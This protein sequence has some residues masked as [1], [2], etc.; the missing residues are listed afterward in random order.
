M[1]RSLTVAYS[2]ASGFQL[3]S[4]PAFTPY[5]RYKFT[6]DSGTNQSGPF[7]FETKL[8]DTPL[9]GQVL[10]L[11]AF[12]SNAMV[13]PV[14]RIGNN[15]ELDLSAGLLGQRSIVNKFGASNSVSNSEIVLTIDGANFAG[16]LTAASAVRIKAGGD[17]ADDASGLGAREITIEGLDGS[18]NAVSESV[19]TAGASASSATTATFLRITR[20]YVSAEGV[21]SD[22]VTG[23]NEAAVTVE[24]TGG[25]QM[26]QIA[27]GAGQSEHAAY[28]VPAGFTA[29]LVAFG[30]F[31][32]SAQSAAVKLWQ[33][34]AIDDV[35]APYSARRT[36]LDFSALTG[37]RR[38]V[39]KTYSSF[40]E[41]TDLWVTAEKSTAGNTNVSA[42]FEMILV[43]NQA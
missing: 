27:A 23:G 24:T 26:L 33:R 43:Q 7:Y 13:A 22:G 29:Y 37:S 42:E 8:L 3:Y 5:V 28:T 11:D 20:A 18:G 2:A 21:Y 16:F 10:R 31:V 9:S 17:A 30:A 15:S 4:A 12:I 6:N 32:E 40:P 34:Q 41:K 38:D 25:V 39:F 19:A 14:Q 36:V 35:S 1:V